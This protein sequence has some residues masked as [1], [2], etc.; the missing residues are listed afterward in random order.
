M[1]RLA[2]N[3]S[4]LKRQR[5]QLKTFRKFLPSLDLKRQQ[6]QLELRKTQ[7]QRN[8]LNEEL[9]RVTLRLPALLELLGSSPI[10]LDGVVTV[11]GVE[12]EESNVVGVRVPVLQQVSFA[13]KPYSMLSKPFWVDHLVEVIEELAEIRIR[14][15]VEDRRIQLLAE[16]L[17]KVTQRVNLFEKVLIPQ[18]EENIRKINIF[19]ADGQRVAVVRSKIAKAKN[20]AKHSRAAAEKFEI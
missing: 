5:D 8:K 12:L 16:A 20:L 1:A 18:A 19:L 14:Q 17:R 4:S 15:E 2:L 13:R 3:K 10:E 7:Q 11:T 6:L 9:E